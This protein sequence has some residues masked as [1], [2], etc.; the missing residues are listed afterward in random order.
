MNAVLDVQESFMTLNREKGQSTGLSALCMEH[1]GLPLS[2]RLHLI[3]QVVGAVVWIFSGV[4][5]LD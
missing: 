4:G 1:F 2:K 3:F 5:G